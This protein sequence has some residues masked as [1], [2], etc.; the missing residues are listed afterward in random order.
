MRRHSQEV[1]N[2]V[3]N[4]IDFKEGGS[5]DGGLLSQ[6]LARIRNLEFKNSGIGRIEEFVDSTATPLVS[7]VSN[8]L[9]FTQSTSTTKKYFNSDIPTE[10]FF[11]FGNTSTLNVDIYPNNTVG[12]SILASI[13]PGEFV[14]IILHD[15]VWIKTF[16]P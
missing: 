16:G 4:R 8:I 1:N 2:V 11:K 12:S 5:I 13:V 15:G 10:T 9:V 7:A 14:K 3:V 6:I